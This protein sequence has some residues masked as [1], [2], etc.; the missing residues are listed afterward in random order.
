MDSYWED[1]V[2]AERAAAGLPPSRD[3]RGHAG[4]EEAGNPAAITQDELLDHVAKASQ[5][6][7]RCGW[8]AGWAAA[9]VEARR[10]FNRERFT[11]F[12][13]G[14]ALAVLAACLMS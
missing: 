5:I 6:G 14:A 10:R 7:Y 3:L 12:L 1:L 13:A 4:R 8:N 2:N 9:R 11:W